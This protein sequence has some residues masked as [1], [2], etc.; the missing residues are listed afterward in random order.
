MASLL[1]MTQGY[2]P[3]YSPFLGFMGVAAAI[4]F[5]S[6]G[7]GYGT[8]KAGVGIA[9]AGTFR[10]AIIMRALIPVVMAGIIA[11]YGLVASVLISG[12]MDPKSKY[13]LF[14]GCIHLASGLCVGMTGLAAGWCIGLVGDMGVRGFAK[15]PKLFVGMV[16][17][18]IFAEV[19]GLYGLIVSLILNT[20][21]S[22]TMCQ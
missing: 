22:N 11:V 8:A 6:A 1:E 14:S 2:C 21:A 18:L 7:A 10:P 20:K 5:S 9:G 17:I 3:A 4:I 13:S 19:L 15:E 12:D 16:L